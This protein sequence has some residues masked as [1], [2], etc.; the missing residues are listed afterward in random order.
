MSVNYEEAVKSTFIG[1]LKSVFLVDDAFPTYSEMFGDRANLDKFG[2]HDR[3]RKLY[4]AFRGNHLPCDIENTFTSGDLHM[5]ERLRKCDLV[6]LDF[7]LDGEGGDNSK[8]IEILRKLAD[9]PHF[10]TVV[11]YTNA[12]LKEVWLDVA[13]NLRPDLRLDPYLSANEIEAA[14]W[15]SVDIDKLLLPTSDALAS[16]L[17]RGIDAVDGNAK[18]EMVARIKETLGDEKG[19]KEDGKRKPNLGT[20]T[21]I[22]LRRATDKRRPAVIGRLDQEDRLGP[23]SLQGKYAPDGPHWLQCRGCFIAI[24]KKSDADNEADLLMSGLRSALLDWKPNFLQILVSEIQNR[25]ELDSVAADPKVFSE[26][27]RQVALSHYLLEQLDANED[28]ESAIES[29]IDRIVETLRL[30]ISSDSRIREFA[31]KVLAD[32]RS[33]LGDKLVQGDPMAKAAALAHVE[34]R[35]DPNGVISFLNAFVSTE[36]FSKSRITTGSVFSVGEEFWMVAT[37]AC[38]LTSRSPGAAQEWMKNIHPIRAMTAIRLRKKKLQDALKKATQGRHAF[39]LHQDET[40]CLSLL[41]HTT[42]TPDPEVFFTLESGKVTSVEGGLPTFRAI[43]VLRADNAPQLSEAAE[44][45]VIGQ[46]RPNYASRVLQLTGAHLSRIGIDFF[47]V[48]DD[49]D[50]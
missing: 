29:V 12:D 48:G 50:E 19:T 21:E 28:P 34:D 16:Y 20:M 1:K 15:A 37:P 38:D 33:G 25:L 4:T 23:R 3:A 13:A 44:Y 39:I 26:A 35:V 46:L 10:N 41:D 18:R 42:A 6:V 5:V 7:H 8:S 32:I 45:T 31:G 11:V 17:T 47:N 43:R 30:R 40:L 9:S 49:R 2:E 24:V 14:W 22:L 36:T 27:N